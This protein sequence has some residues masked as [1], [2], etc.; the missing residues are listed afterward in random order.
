MDRITPPPEPREPRRFTIRAE[1]QDQIDVI[2]S[3]LGI[4]PATVFQMVLSLGVNELLDTL[5]GA[6]LI[7]LNPP[8]L[9]PLGQL[10]MQPLDLTDEAPV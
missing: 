7:A 10:P 9:V 8:R 2:A 4:E 1:K 3:A 5:T 6:G